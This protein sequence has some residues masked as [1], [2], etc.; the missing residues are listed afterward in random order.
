MCLKTEAGT[1][2]SGPGDTV[3]V[4]DDGGGIMLGRAELSDA[5]EPV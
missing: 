1:A 2:R 4:D 3:R 5:R